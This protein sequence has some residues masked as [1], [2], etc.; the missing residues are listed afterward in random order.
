MQP[1]PRHALRRGAVVLAEQAKV[2][3]RQP[4]YR[5][6]SGGLLRLT[7]AFQLQ[8]LSTAHIEASGH[9]EICR[10]TPIA[11]DTER[12]DVLGTRFS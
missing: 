8:T 4:L 3:Q 12:R 11:T 1:S 9:D 6:G 10:Q 5:E 2:E 7:P